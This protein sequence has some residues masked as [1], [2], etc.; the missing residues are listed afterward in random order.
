MPPLQSFHS[1]LYEPDLGI[2]EHSGPGQL[3]PTADVFGF[4]LQSRISSTPQQNQRADRCRCFLD[5]Q[6]LERGTLFLRFRL[7]S[8]RSVKCFASL[9]LVYTRTQATQI[10][11]AELVANTQG[12]VAQNKVASV[13][14]LEAL[15]NSVVR[16]RDSKTPELRN[17][18]EIIFGFL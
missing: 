16:P 11:R 4:P 2:V 7:L 1:V 8:Y 17:V 13:Q 18:P 5:M 12:L 10:R 14:T 9:A 3:N 15:Q 6:N